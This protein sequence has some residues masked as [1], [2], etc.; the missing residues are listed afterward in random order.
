MPWMSPSWALLKEL[1][2]DLLQFNVEDIGFNYNADI[3]EFELT[4]VAGRWVMP[5]AV[6][7]SYRA[8]TFGH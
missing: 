6:G 2:V 1:G 3:V 4:I 8:P 7:L 5:A